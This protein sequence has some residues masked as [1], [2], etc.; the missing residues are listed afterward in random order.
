MDNGV[1]IVIPVY[2]EVGAIEKTLNDIYHYMGHSS[3]PFEIIVVDDGSADGTSE[4][5]EKI[6]FP[7]LKKVAHSRNMGYGAA[8]KSG[9]NFSKYG[10]IAI[11]DADGTYPH[12][13]IPQLV[14]LADRND[15]VVGARS[16]Q[17]VNIPLIR[18]PAKWAI[19]KLA[20]FLARRK[21]PDLNSGLRVMKKD[22]VNLF[23]NILPDG[24]SF[25]T[26][27]TLAML[28]NGYKV[29]YL[30]IDYYARSGKSKIRPIRDTLNF[31]QLVIRTIMYF[32]PLRI[33][34]PISLILFLASFVGIIFRVIKG[35]GFLV[36]SVIIFI[37]A[38]Q[39]LTTGMIADFIDKRSGRYGDMRR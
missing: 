18:K 12:Q 6:S 10:L 21:I 39:V 34:L 22:L 37:S 4:L 7:N 26:T 27:I 32:D 33:F 20:D 1:S 28:S 23:L 15:M 3:L 35:E 24:F 19:K 9:I 17:N 14:E 36:V 13:V 16:S 2:N 8:L 25:T 38:I 30:P 11:T 29:A 31:V 5:I